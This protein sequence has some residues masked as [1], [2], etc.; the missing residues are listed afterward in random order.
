MGRKTSTGGWW[1]SG[2]RPKRRQY[3]WLPADDEANVYGFW[4]PTP[5]E[6]E[7]RKAEIR[8]GRVLQ[9]VAHRGDPWKINPLAAVPT[10]ARSF[11]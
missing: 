4:V 5:E 6:I 10:R 3:D 8:E 9:F 11:E 1:S 7:Q 2:K